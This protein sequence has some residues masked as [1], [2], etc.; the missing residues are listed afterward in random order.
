MR[1]SFKHLDFKARDR[2]EAL[3]R[4]GHTK[5]EIAEVL[6]MHK[7]TI[8]RE[9]ERRKRET[10]EYKAEVA[11][12]KAQ[13]KRGNS[14]FQGM[15]IE[16]YPW[17]RKHIIQELKMLRS[18][19][20]IAGRMKRE[21]WSVRVSGDAIYRWLRSA[22]GHRYC[23]YL[24]TKRYYKKPRTNTEKRE[25]IPNMTSIHTMGYDLESVTEGDTFLSPKKVSKVAVALVVWRNSKLLKGD[26]VKSL[27]PRNTTK[28]MKT[29]YENYKSDALVL[30]Q[31]R[32]NMEHEKFGIPAYFCDPASPRQ[33]PL[34]ES[35]IG[36]CR[37]WFWPKGTNLAKVPRE[38]FLEKIE[39]LNNKYRKTL[40]YR[41]ANEVAR[42]CGIIK[43]NY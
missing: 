10:G 41:S 14:K 15:K 1:N 9:I 32:E 19:D 28:V 13:V 33:K 5:K 6:G 43:S 25:M 22:Y 40:Q 34:I 29:I 12:H 3:W 24:C 26:I 42:E 27:K 16:K 18:P 8:S 39:I 38:E 20:E 35:S 7:S 31:G 23:K 4:N 37:R 36:L 21:K 11:N 30:D 2:I 17:L